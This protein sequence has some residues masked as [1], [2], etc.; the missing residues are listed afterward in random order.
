MSRQLKETEKSQALAY[1]KSRMTV[2]KEA[3]KMIISP[4]TVVIVRHKT[5]KH[6][7]F[8]HLK[9]NG[10]PSILNEEINSF[11]KKENQKNF[12]RSLRK[13]QNRKI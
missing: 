6:R 7:L 5:G 9:G 8:K 13:I 4:S 10:R 1:L 2:R 3:L 12:R 11:I